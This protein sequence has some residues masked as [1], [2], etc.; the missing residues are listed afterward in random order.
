MFRVQKKHNLYCNVGGSLNRKNG[1]TSW[2]A[3]RKHAESLSKTLQT[4]VDEK[5]AY[6]ICLIYYPF[7]LLKKKYYQDEICREINDIKLEE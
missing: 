2:M 3:I 1:Q 5:L 6:I 7:F 4:F